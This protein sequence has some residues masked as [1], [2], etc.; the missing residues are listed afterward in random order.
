MKTAIELHP[1]AATH[2]GPGMRVLEIWTSRHGKNHLRTI[3]SCS[4]VRERV[5]EYGIYQEFSKTIQI[6]PCARATAR[7][8]ETAHNVALE[9]KDALVE[10]AQAFYATKTES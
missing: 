6:V 10:A 4:I 2:D 7:A 8:Y 1:V 3:A 5:K 9:Q